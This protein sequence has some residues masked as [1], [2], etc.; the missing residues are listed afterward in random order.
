MIQ[1]FMCCEGVT[2][3]EPICAF[4]RKAVCYPEIDVIRKTQSELRN[5]TYLLDNRRGIHAGY[6]FVDR[7]AMTA[8]KANCK[9]IAYHQDADGS[10]ADVY[11]NV[12]EWL[13][14]YAGTY[15]CLAIVPKE[16]VESWLLADKQA[17]AA[18]FGSE[19]KRPALPKEPEKIWGKDNDSKSNYPKNVMRRVLEQYRKRPHREIREIY[20][21][22]AEQSNID[23][24]KTRCPVSFA[25]FYDDLQ[26]FMSTVTNGGTHA[27]S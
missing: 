13:S 18:V 14:K 19:P 22:I 4:M 23:T 24:L 10:Y 2:D 3:F 5:E 25:R 16:M 26:G 1:V 27:H 7:L 12:T 15:F 8:K 21:E 6:T 20:T 9:H 17:Y 11:K